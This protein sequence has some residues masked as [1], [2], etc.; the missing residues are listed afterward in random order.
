[1]DENE[2]QQEEETT[3]ATE[4]EARKRAAEFEESWQPRLWS[5]IILLVVIVGY[6]I[7]LVVANSGKV[8][9][10][11]LFASIQV[12]KIWLILLCFVIGLVTGVL[13][14]QMYRH[15]KVERKHLEEQAA[16]AAKQ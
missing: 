15:R 1:M 13:V 8:K 9:I 10:S 2:P 7:G 5:K 16:Q 11:F 6:G 4:E 14:S 12:S 3:A